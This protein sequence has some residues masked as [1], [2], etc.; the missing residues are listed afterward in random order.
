MNSNST[1]HF[2]V[3]LGPVA[4]AILVSAGCNPD[5]AWIVLQVYVHAASPEVFT[6][7]MGL[8]LD[9]SARDALGLWEA[10]SVRRRRI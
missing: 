1:P 3:D 8:L 6:H 7:H 10:I 4:E 9:W 5:D 2:P